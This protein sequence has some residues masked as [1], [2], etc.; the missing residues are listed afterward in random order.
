MTNTKTAIQ[1]QNTSKTDEM[2]DPS[3]QGGEGI[4]SV[5]GGRGSS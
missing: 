5:G 2:Y 4:V 1:I 3:L